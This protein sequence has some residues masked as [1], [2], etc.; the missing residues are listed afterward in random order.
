MLRICV[1]AVL[2]GLLPVLGAQPLDRPVRVKRVVGLSYPSL[3]LIEGVQGKVQLAAVISRNG[4]VENVRVL[5]GA[6]VLAS[7]AEKALKMWRFEPCT[8]SGGKCETTVVFS[9]IIGDEHCDGPKCPDQ[10]IFDLPNM[11][12][13]RSSRARSVVN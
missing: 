12:E 4:T 8:T 1:L 3:A 13:I 7:A 2:F 5:A 11:V 9:F 10:C 6:E